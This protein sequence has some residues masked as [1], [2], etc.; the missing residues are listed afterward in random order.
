MNP[1]MLAL[2]HKKNRRIAPTVQ[3]KIVGFLKLMLCWFLIAS[4]SVDMSDWP[5]RCES[6]IS[7]GPG[8]PPVRRD[9]DAKWCVKQHHRLADHLLSHCPVTS[10]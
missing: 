10:L 6:A 4:A 3:L 8:L 2:R 5:N 7:H 1:C 9:D